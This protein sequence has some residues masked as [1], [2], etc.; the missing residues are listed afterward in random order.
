MAEDKPFSIVTETIVGR[1]KEDYG[2]FGN[3]AT[4]YI[5][6]H[7][8]GTGEDAHLTTKVFL[9][10]LKPRLSPQVETVKDIMAGAV[11]LA[12]IGSVIVGAIIFIPYIVPLLG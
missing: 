7:I 1:T 9:D 5:G 2:N 12:S 11:L 10:L 3:K 8:V 4:G 6:K